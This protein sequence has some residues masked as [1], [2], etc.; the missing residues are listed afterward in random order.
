MSRK[1]LSVKNWYGR[2]K[3]QNS[4]KVKLQCSNV[5]RVTSQEVTVTGPGFPRTREWR[6]RVSA[7][8]D[9]IN[10]CHSREACPRPDRGAG[11]QKNSTAEDL[12]RFI[13]KIQEKF[14]IWLFTRP[15]KNRTVIYVFWKRVLRWRRETFEKCFPLKAG[16][17]TGICWIFR[18]GSQ[19]SADFE[20][21][22][23]AKVSP[24][25]IKE[26]N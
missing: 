10:I 4:Q 17:T 25:Q 22:H 19:I 16:L 21:G 15:S 26:Q 12:P 23:F 8:H 2:K 1:K 6:N 20:M 14:K 3:A 7:R 11:I 5:M 18:G 13:E 24:D 9:R